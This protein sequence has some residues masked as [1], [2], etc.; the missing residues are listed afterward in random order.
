M[1]HK[2][3]FLFLLVNPYDRYS[4]KP[5]ILVIICV[6]A[7]IRVQA[8]SHGGIEKSLTFLSDQNVN[9]AKS[10]DYY[11]ETEHRSTSVSD[12]VLTRFL[13]IFPSFL[14]IAVSGAFLVGLAAS[15]GILYLSKWIGRKKK[16]KRQQTNCVNV[17]EQ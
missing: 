4:V 5:N 8:G 7:F 17:G 6:N 10:D 12:S 15:L 2:K 1:P 16:G 9:T 11:Q 3:S 13:N 14:I